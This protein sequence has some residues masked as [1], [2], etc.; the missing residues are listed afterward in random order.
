FPENSAGNKFKLNMYRIVQEQLNNILKYASATKVRIKLCV[1]KK[2][3]ILTISDN[4]IGF[5]T[6]R[7]QKGIGLRNIKS[8]AA[9]YYGTADF[10]SEPGHGC[11]LTVAIPVT[12]ALQNND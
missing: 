9:S 6:T 2:K 5:D 8:R 3:V 4:G 7:I 12:S 11:M 10:T 1:A